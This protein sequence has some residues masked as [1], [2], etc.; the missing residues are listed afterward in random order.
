MELPEDYQKKFHSDPAE[1]KNRAGLS[2]NAW[3]EQLDNF[4]AKINPSRTKKGLKPYSHPYIGQ[5]LNACGIHDAAT[6]YV[7]FRK[8]EIEARSFP[9]LFERLSSPCG[10]TR[11]R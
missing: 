2:R 5:R 6:A 4:A 1:K 11:G 9:A 3:E 8:L 7:F 10:G